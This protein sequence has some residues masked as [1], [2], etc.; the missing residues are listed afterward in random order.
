MRIPIFDRLLREAGF[1]RPPEPSP[2]PAAT[3]AEPGPA[4]ENPSPVAATN[5]VP[6][7][8]SVGVLGQGVQGFS[9]AD[10]AT[11]IFKQFLANQ[12]ALRLPNGR[13]IPLGPSPMNRARRLQFGHALAMYLTVALD[14][15][16]DIDH[17]LTVWLRARREDMLNLLNAHGV[18]QNP[19]DG[20]HEEEMQALRLT[21]ALVQGRAE[22]V[23]EGPEES[24]AN[25]LAGLDSGD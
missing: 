2:T 1:L 16:D 11:R 4:G 14:G 15:T 24:H 12:I 23:S 6:R 21:V 17:P 20:W 9:P 5:E 3:P 13:V 8:Q 10:T 25:V 19:R 7:A 18:P 22:R